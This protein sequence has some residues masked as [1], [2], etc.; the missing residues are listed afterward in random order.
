MELTREMEL[1]FFIF[2]TSFFIWFHFPTLAGRCPPANRASLHYFREIEKR[3]RRMCTNACNNDLTRSIGGVGVTFSSF[4]S[5]S[6][7]LI[8]VLSPVVLILNERCHFAIQIYFYTW[9]WIMCCVI[10]LRAISTLPLGKWWATI[11]SRFLPLFVILS[12]IYLVTRIKWKKHKILS[13]WWRA[14]PNV[15]LKW[16]MWI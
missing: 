2:H 7:L 4:F 3:P 8:C 9:W 6:I 10:V 13:E 15:K 5:H 11:A 16:T 12:P 1:F 14:P